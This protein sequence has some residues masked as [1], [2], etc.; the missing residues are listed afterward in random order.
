MEPSGMERGRDRSPSGLGLLLRGEA[1]HICLRRLAGAHALI[2]IGDD[3]VERE[4][5]GPEQL[6][7]PWGTR[8]K[9]ETHARIWNYE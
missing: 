1:P 2:E 8:R 7:A 5:G 4:P 3:D 9:D 6:S